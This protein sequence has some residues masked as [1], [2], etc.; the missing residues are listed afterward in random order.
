[1]AANHGQFVSKRNLVV[2]H[3]IIHSDQEPI[4]EYIRAFAPRGK[5]V[6]SEEICSVCNV[7]TVCPL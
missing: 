2:S 3:L 6:A 7:L 1:M 5:V 4:T